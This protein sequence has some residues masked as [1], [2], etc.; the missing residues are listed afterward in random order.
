MSAVLALAFDK[1]HIVSTVKTLGH[2][3]GF[4]ISGIDDAILHEEISRR[5]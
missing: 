3:R 1:S 2:D 5:S 4:F